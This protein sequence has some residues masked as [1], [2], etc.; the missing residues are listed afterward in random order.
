ML[1]TEYL[2][3]LSKCPFCDC[4]DRTVRENSNAYLTYS[5]AP[6]HKHHLLVLPRR[7]V[8]SFLTLTEEELDGIESLLRSGA[9][10]LS[11]LGYEDYSI[12]VRNGDESGKSVKHLHY[13]I[14]PHVHIGNIDYGGEERRIMTKEETDALM[15]EFARYQSDL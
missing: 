4:A 7:H 3:N 1:Y 14:V 10:L 6:Y 2:K 9:K 12:L 13:H 15:E 11:F 8:E 5:L